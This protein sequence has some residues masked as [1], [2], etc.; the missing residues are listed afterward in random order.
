MELTEQ[1]IKQSNEKEIFDL[2]VSTLIK[3]NEGFDPVIIT[4]ILELKYLS[5]LGI[6]PVLDSCAI[7]GITN[8]LTVSTNKGCFVCPNCHTN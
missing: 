3:I 1:V 6:K 7:C 5:Y 2:L 8:I 4:N